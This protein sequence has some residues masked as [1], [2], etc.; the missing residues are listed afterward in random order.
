MLGIAII[1]YNTFEKTIGCIE[2][3]KKTTHIKYKVY[4]L[5]NKSTNNS[6]EVLKTKYEN[7]PDVCLILSKENTGYAR[8]NNLCVDYMLK[9]GCEF[10]V[11]SNNDIICFDG[12]IDRLVADLQ[13]HE[14]CMLVGPQIVSPEGEFQPSVRIHE[15]YGLTYLFRKGTYLKKFFSKSNKR[16][17]LM[18]QNI[19]EFTHVEW[20]C[21]AF[22]AFSVKKFVEIGKFDSSTF[23]FFEESILG[24]RAQQAGEKF[25][26]DPKIK[27]AHYH[28]ASTGGGKN[29][30]MRIAECQS[31]Q[32]YFRNYTDAS[33][34]FIKILQLIRLLEVLYSFGK[35]KDFDAIKKYVHAMSQFKV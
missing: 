22:F 21:G 31:E 10:G 1:N 27:V 30:Y 13:E 19:K 8:G 11:V 18:L 33:F 4:L 6:A 15:Y 12:A 28:S 9:D 16:D 35:A 32:I 23:L 14:D 25:G 20:V 5:D 26:Y 2:S 7:D 17:D 29:I 34:V 3:I 24:K